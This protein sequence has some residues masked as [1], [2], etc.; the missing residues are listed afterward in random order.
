MLLELVER[1][2]LTAQSP[3]VVAARGA[4]V[5]MEPGGLE[6]VMVAHT[7]AVVVMGGGRTTAVPTNILVPVVPGA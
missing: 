3:L 2:G 4:G 7:V 5:P 6:A 1:G